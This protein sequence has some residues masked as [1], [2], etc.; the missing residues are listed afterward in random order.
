MQTTNG[1]RYLMGRARTGFGMDRV[2]NVLLS[3]HRYD[4]LGDVV[5]RDQEM[6]TLDDL[7]FKFHGGKPMYDSKDVFAAAAE[8]ARLNGRL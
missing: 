5:L 8:C 6:R 1:Y 3:I 7:V 2:L 4:K